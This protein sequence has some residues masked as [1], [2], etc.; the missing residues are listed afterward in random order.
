MR[1]TEARAVEDGSVQSGVQS[2]VQSV[3]RALDV[4]EALAAAG[5][6]ASLTDLAAACGLPVPTLHRLAGTLADRG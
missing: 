2:G 3:H 4:L 5:G 6:T 1:L